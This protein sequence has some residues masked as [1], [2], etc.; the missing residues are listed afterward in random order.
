MGTSWWVR[1]R[2]CRGAWWPANSRSPFP[3]GR[4]N[5]HHAPEPSNPRLSKWRARRGNGP[6]TST[7]PA[8]GRHN[9]VHPLSTHLP[10]FYCQPP[11][12]A[13]NWGASRHTVPTPRTIIT[14]HLLLLN[15]ACVCVCKQTRGSP[16]LL[17]LSFFERRMVTKKYEINARFLCCSAPEKGNEQLLQIVH[18]V[19]A[20]I[21]FW[22]IAL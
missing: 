10:A 9:P 15:T 14:G 22:T 12:R 19:F 3:A 18:P 1:G 21:R 20:T 16:Y 7:Q 13:P 6:S 2:Q 5:Q 8:F 11:D 4:A 17:T